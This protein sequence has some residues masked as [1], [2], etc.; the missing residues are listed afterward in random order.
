MMTMYK[1]VDTFND[2]VISKHRTAAAAGRAASKEPA[3]LPVCLLDADD[4]VVDEDSRDAQD[5]YSA[6]N[7]VEW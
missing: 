3:T 5:F 1:L 2:R 7:G 4:N 6:R